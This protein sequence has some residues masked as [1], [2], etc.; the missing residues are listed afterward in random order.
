MGSVALP[1]WF[2][3]QTLITISNFHLDPPGAKCLIHRS[4]V[5]V[6]W[7]S[8]VVKIMNCPN[9]KPF[10]FQSTQF[11]VLSSTNLD[12]AIYTLHGSVM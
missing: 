4:V 2:N 5:Y 9:L 11:E 12:F 10:I 6:V 3:E 8:V 7:C 1:G